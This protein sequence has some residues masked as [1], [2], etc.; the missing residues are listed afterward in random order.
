[1][2]RVMDHEETA[3]YIGCAPG[4]LRV[5]VQQQRIPHV[6]VNR[7]VKFRRPDLDDWLDQHFVAAREGQQQP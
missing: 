3:A 6:R 7:L 2:E 5:W 4:T 1:M